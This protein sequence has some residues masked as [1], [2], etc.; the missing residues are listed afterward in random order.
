MPI[1]IFKDQTGLL[2]S[3]GGIRGF[4]LTKMNPSGTSYIQEQLLNHLFN[5]PG[6]KVLDNILHSL[7]DTSHTISGR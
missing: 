5:Q 4:L 3:H 7:L 2:W 1:F 6:Y